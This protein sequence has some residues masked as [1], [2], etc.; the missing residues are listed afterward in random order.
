[1][2]QWSGE[3]DVEIVLDR[4]PFY[5]ESGGQVG[6]RGTL[7]GDGYSARVLDTVKPLP[8]LIVHRSRM[9]GGTVRLGDACTAEVARSERDATRRNHTATHLLHA[10]LREILGDH[11]RQSGSLVEPDRFRF[12]F[13]HF[14]V[15]S[16]D[17][18]EA[19]EDFVNRHT[20]ENIEVETL[21]MTHDEAVDKGAVALF[22]EKYGDTVRVV[23]VPGVSMELCG[24]THVSRTGDIGLFRITHEGGIAAGVRRIEGVTGTKV[25]DLLRA[26]DA[27][28]SQLAGKVK[29]S[30][31]D[32]PG[33]M[34][35]ILE[36]LQEQDRK[37]RD[38]MQSIAEGG[39]SDAGDQ[40]RETEG[41]RYLAAE[42]PGQDAAG[43]REAADRY[44]DRIGSGI[45]LL[46]A[47]EGD[48]AFLVV[49][50]TK[51]MMEKFPAGELVRRLAPI[52][53]GGG[54]GRPDMAQAGGK[55]PDALP[56]LLDSVDDVIREMAT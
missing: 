33:K 44:R 3:G 40:I 6:D 29:A 17:Q 37:V 46:A 4:T 19:V 53:G 51:D 35:K 23:S 42:L 5:G 9:T 49:R 43:L 12:D 39:T 45:V 7:K 16:A 30:V 31:Q 14:E 55:N 8:D 21:E 32:L 26:D 13:N 22:D 20:L 2:D 18:I 52:V 47:R 38:L 50:V 34:E 11:V 24:G 27:L 1:V 41:V 56:E 54:G 36:T 10:A 28:L 48:K 15:V 25:L